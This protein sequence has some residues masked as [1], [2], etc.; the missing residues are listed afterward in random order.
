MYSISLAR[1]E[2]DVLPVHLVQRL[3]VIDGGKQTEK[4]RPRARWI[5]CDGQLVCH[6]EIDN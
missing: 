5:L 4:D 1:N 2:Q 6:W 3:Q